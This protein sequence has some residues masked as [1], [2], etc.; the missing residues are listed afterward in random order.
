MTIFIED[1][2]D[3]SDGFGSLLI[4]FSETSPCIL[5]E[6]GLRVWSIL[7]LKTPPYSRQLNPVLLLVI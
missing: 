7:L 1:V 3:A 5:S 6:P 4:G 2:L